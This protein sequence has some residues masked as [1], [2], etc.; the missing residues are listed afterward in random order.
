MYNNHFGFSLKDLTYIIDPNQDVML[1]DLNEE[2][3]YSGLWIKCNHVTSEEV[4]EIFPYHPDDY[5]NY[6]C[7]IF[8]ERDYVC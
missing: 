7:V 3:I 2:I 5:H 1:I 6:I 4:I 8:K